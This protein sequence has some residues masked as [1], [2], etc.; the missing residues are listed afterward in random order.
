MPNPWAEEYLESLLPDLVSETG[1]SD[2]DDLDSD[3]VDDRMVELYTLWQHSSSAVRCLKLA[4]A[5]LERC[6]PDAPASLV[7]D[8]IECVEDCTE[9][10]LMRLKMLPALRTAAEAAPESG[11]SQ[12]DL[13]FALE[14]LDESE[15]AMA[16]YRKALEH[17]DDLCF[18]NFRDCLNNTGWDLYLQK[19]YEDA[20]PWFVRACW[21]VPSPEKEMAHGHTEN[22]EPPYKLAF[23]NILLCLAKLGHL[24]E[25]AEKLT[26]YF[27]CFGRLPRYETEALRKLGLDADIAFIRRQIKKAQA[28]RSME[29]LIKVGAQISIEPKS[30][31]DSP[32]PPAGISVVTK[33]SVEKALDEIDSG[34]LHGV[35]KN[36]KSTVYCLETRGRHYP[37]KYV[38]FRARKIQGI[39]RH[40]FSG[41]PRTNIQ[42]QNL[43]YVVIEDRCGNTCNFSESKDDGRATIDNEKTRQLRWVEYDRL[44]RGKGHGVEF[45]YSENDHEFLVAF[46]EGF[47]WRNGGPAT[48]ELAKACPV[49]IAE[50]SWSGIIASTRQAVGVFL[51]DDSNFNY[52]FRHGPIHI[53]ING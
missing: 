40:G 9:Q 3:N 26:A 5:L 46:L 36:R 45:L 18:L 17:P 41:G 52:S 2:A 29:D 39:K 47:G 53:W 51:S 21:I 11:D 1:D 48:V 28:K 23:E 15:E 19:Q 31:E 49:L 7:A 50:E 30:T 6:T 25:A 8:L 42:L 33:E 12:A 32:A 43:G 24:P 35:P 22:L 20:L 14:A 16:R 37:P 10:F 4:L 38:L 34:G 44:D 27:D 13:A